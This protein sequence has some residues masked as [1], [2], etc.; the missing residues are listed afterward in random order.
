MLLANKAPSRDTPNSPPEAEEGSSYNPGN[1]AGFLYLLLGFSV[2]RPLFIAGKLIVH[3]NATVTARNIF[4]GCSG[5]GP[6]P[7]RPHGDPGP[8]HAMLHRLLQILNDVAALLHR[9]R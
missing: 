8:A 4:I 1:V 7:R 3:D 5:R 9:T 6:E 2:F